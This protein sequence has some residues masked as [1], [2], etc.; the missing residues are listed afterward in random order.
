MMDYI[1]IGLLII[2]I[3]L[4]II[5]ISKNIN[6][7]RITERLGKLE[8][9]RMVNTNEYLEQAWLDILDSQALVD[10]LYSQ[11]LNDIIENEFEDWGDID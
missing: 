10:L 1:I 11:T 9:N 7:S 5:S 8:T 6:E 3:I 4:T 2:L